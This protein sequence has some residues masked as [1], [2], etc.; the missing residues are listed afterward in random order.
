ML[1]YISPV[2]VEPSL[3]LK[4]DYLLTP[5]TLNGVSTTFLTKAANKMQYKHFDYARVF[6]KL[7]VEIN[8]NSALTSSDYL[9]V[10]VQSGTELDVNNKIVNGSTVSYI[11]YESDKYPGKKINSTST[12]DGIVDYYLEVFAD[13]SAGSLRGGLRIS[14]DSFSYQADGTYYVAKYIAFPMMNT[15]VLNPVNAGKN[16]AL[17]NFYGMKITPFGAFVNNANVKLSASMYVPE[18]PV[19]TFHQAILNQLNI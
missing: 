3:R 15:S 19:A 18:F 9:E 12:E 2:N 14:K 17:D 7:E 16:T 8:D 11:A 5:Q 6:M 10:F 1:D 4:P 13:E